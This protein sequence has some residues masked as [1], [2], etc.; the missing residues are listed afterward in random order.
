MSN[1]AIHTLNESVSSWP[2]SELRITASYTPAFTASPN[3]TVNSFPFSFTVYAF[4]SSVSRHNFFI[5]RHTLSD[6]TLIRLFVFVMLLT[7]TSLITS[8]PGVTCIIS[9]REAVLDRRSALDFKEN[10][11]DRAVSALTL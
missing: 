11:P 5:K 6:N 3:V 7:T 10:R 8:C 1:R 2:D 4:I 9:R